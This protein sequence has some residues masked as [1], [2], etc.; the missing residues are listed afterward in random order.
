MFTDIDFVSIARAFGAQGF[1]IEKP[2]DIASTVKM[3]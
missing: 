1:R 3:L 2:E